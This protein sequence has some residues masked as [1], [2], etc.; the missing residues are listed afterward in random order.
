MT[1]PAP[2]LPPLMLPRHIA[3]DPALSAT[4]KLIA[5]AVFSAI[6]DTG[7]CVEPL[8]TL[9]RAVCVADST[10]REAMRQL[11]EAGH[12]SPIRRP[13]QPTA[14]AMRTPPKSG[15]PPAEIRRGSP[16]TTAI[17]PRRNPAT[18]F[19]EAIDIWPSLET[20]P[21]E[22]GDPHARAFLPSLVIQEPSSS[23]AGRKEG[24]GRK[25]RR[26]PIPCPA[27]FTPTQAT[28]ALLAKRRPD[29]DLSYELAKFI[30][31]WTEGKGSVTRRPDWNASFIGWVERADG[32]PPPG[33][34]APGGARADAAGERLS[35]TSRRLLEIATGADH[36]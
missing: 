19:P 25:P 2:L 5:A 9:C 29:V 33:A 36:S 21:P 26:M 30:R 13:G 16:V 23:Q 32:T 3:G 8:A 6:D 27:D 24:A 31:Y 34:A 18:P 10:A 15:D 20:T 7:L 17:E 12:L 35:P 4:A 11:V 14:W 1:Q 22:T 28:Q